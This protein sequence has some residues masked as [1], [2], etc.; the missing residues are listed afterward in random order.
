MRIAAILLAGLLAACTSAEGVLKF[1]DEATRPVGNC[2][3]IRAEQERI[4]A[5]IASWSNAGEARDLGVLAGTTVMATGAITGGAA[6]LAAGAA[7]TVAQNVNVDLSADRERLR[8]LAYERRRMCWNT[9]V[10]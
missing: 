5:R 2:A 6:A 9:D 3:D 8:F 10:E 1:Y 7:V 4:A